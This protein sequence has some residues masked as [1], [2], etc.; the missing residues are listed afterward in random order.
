MKDGKH[1]IIHQTEPNSP[2][3]TR[4]TSSRFQECFRSDQR[5][6][7][8]SESLSEIRIPRHESPALAPLPTAT[9][10]RFFRR[11]ICNADLVLAA[12]G[13]RTVRSLR[14]AGVPMSR[15]YETLDCGIPNSLSEVAYS[16]SRASIGRFVHFGRLVFHKGTHLAIEA[17]A[18]SNPA[19]TLDVV[20]RGPELTRC[21]IWRRAWGWTIVFASWTGMKTERT[22]SPPSR[23]I[24][25]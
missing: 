23:T 20:G 9:A 3:A 19:V 16:P 11:G 18:K 4:W 14:A 5:Q 12:G 13:A 10:D 7:L 24:A 15:I 21:R 25:E 1:V 22:W 17:V 8:L 2:V 6:Y